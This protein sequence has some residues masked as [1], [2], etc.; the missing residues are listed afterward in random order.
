MILYLPLEIKVREIQ[1]YLL[2]AVIAASRGHQVMIAPAN[3]FWLYLRFNLLRKG[4]YLL[5]NM[6]V[7]SWSQNIYEHFIKKG[8]DLY[9]HEQEASILWND[10]GKFLLDYNIY[11]G[12]PLPFKGV[13]CWGA[14]DTEEYKNFFNNKEAIFFN[15][16]SPRAE[17]WNQ[18]FSLLHKRENIELL[19]SY[20]LIV[21]NF[22]L[23]MGERHW[24][25]WM[26]LSRKS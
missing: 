16:G 10:F 3:S 26:A 5:K 6:N 15:T 2:F 19:K 17:L 12:Q 18:K 13:F 11:L 8:F 22:G 24:T 25:E 1:S 4:C 7:P 14:R 21:S 23:F 20:I 9:C